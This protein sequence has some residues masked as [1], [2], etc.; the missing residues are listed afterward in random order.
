[1]GKHPTPTQKKKNFKDI[2]LS[3]ARE[4]CFLVGHLFS[5]RLQKLLRVGPGGILLMYL[6]LRLKTG[7]L[8]LSNDQSLSRACF[9]VKLQRQGKALAYAFEVFIFSN[10]FKNKNKHVFVLHV[11]QIP[12]RL[13]YV[14]FYV[15]QA[16]GE[17]RQKKNKTMFSIPQKLQTKRCMFISTAGS[18]VYQK[19]RRSTLSFPH[20]LHL[21]KHRVLAKLPPAP[22]VCD[23][24]SGGGLSLDWRSPKGQ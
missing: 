5:H 22:K 4:V 11:G 10:Y 1:M 24:S 18:K 3:K 14:F 6:K 16:H 12:R 8:G 2:Q 7:A 23:R 9:C 21:L 19:D 15:S 13:S 17:T 20:V